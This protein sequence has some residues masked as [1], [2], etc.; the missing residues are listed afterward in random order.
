MGVAGGHHI[1]DTHHHVLLAIGPR[2]QGK[3]VTQGLMMGHLDGRGMSQSL[4]QP[5]V[6]AVCRG[7][8]IH[9]ERGEIILLLMC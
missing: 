4:L 7:P 9:I 6:E 5:E 8:R 1:M 2:L 3:V